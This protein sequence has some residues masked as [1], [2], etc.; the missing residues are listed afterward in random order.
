MEKIG[1][2]LVWFPL[3]K[4]IQIL[5]PKMLYALASLAAT[6][7][8]CVAR[9]KRRLIAKE[10]SLILPDTTR[11]N[12]TPIIKRA[13]NQYVK[14]QLENVLMGA[15]TKHSVARFASIEGRENIDVALARGKGAII[16]LSHFGAYLTI[17]PIL[18]FKGYK[19]NQ[20]TQP[21]VANH[22]DSIH[23]LKVKEYDRLPVTFFESDTSLMAAI[24]CLKKNEL[25]AIAFDG[26][27]GDK[28][29]ESA[30]CGMP[31]LLAPG[32]LRIAM[33][34]GATIIPTFIVR[35]KDNSHKLIHHKPFDLHEGENHDESLAINMQN[36]AAIFEK[37]I[38]QYPCHYAVHL[39]R[40]RHR[41]NKGMIKHHIF[42]D[43][44]P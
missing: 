16:L 23:Q 18:G 12:L 8:Y 39:Q 15:F 24:R 3:R 17:L 7:Y 35:Q 13:F 43:Q 41:A 20:L 29:V 11:E 34:T 32:A 44:R 10:L 30:M 27:N 5:P 42:P 36:L 19:I 40:M 28:W 26:R 6:A 22:H 25:L 1:F 38:Y 31:A 4:I 14:V 37:Y 9:E 33:K 21:P 2:F